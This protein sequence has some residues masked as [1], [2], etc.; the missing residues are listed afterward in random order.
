MKMN[1]PRPAVKPANITFFKG[2][3]QLADSKTSVVLTMAGQFTRTITSRL[4]GLYYEIKA[5]N[6]TMEK[7]ELNET[8]NAARTTYLE[9]MGMELK[10]EVIYVAGQP[11]WFLDN[12]RTGIRRGYYEDIRDQIRDASSLKILT[13]LSKVMAEMKARFIDTAD[14]GLKNFHVG[15]FNRL[16]TAHDV[17]RSEL[18]TATK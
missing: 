12:S 11:C 1:L 4:S 10:G 8:V 6:P 2:K 9:T 7:A 3:A 16:Q 14:G 17:R 15:E 13:G 5:L 18:A